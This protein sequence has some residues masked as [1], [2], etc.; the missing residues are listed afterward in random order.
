MTPEVV[1]RH[2]DDRIIGM[3][4]VSSYCV[5]RQN[6][7]NITIK[8]REKLIGV[9]TSSISS[10]SEI[11]DS[12]TKYYGYYV[13]FVENR[14]IDLYRLE[15]KSAFTAP[16]RNFQALIFKEKLESCDKFHFKYNKKYKDYLKAT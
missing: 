11:K 15:S 14:I 13:Y 7:Y 1:K 2:I 16:D 10:I 8:F 12:R 6:I 3:L 9:D 4:K 5:T